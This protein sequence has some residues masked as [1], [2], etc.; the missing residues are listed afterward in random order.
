MKKP[1]AVIVK[2]LG[3]GAALNHDHRFSKQ[4]L[5]LDPNIFD[6]LD[7]E[8]RPLLQTQF[9]RDSSRTIVTENDSPDLGLTYS[10]NFY[11]GCEH[12]CIYCYA[13]PTH[14][15]LNL[16]PGLDFESKI[17]IKEAAPQLLREKLMSPR[18]KPETIMMSGVT[19]CYQPAER[20]FKI[21]KQCLEV[22]NEFKNPVSVITKNSLV[23]RDIDILRDLASSRS[24]SVVLSMT[25]LNPTISK[26]MEP[27]ASVPAARLKAIE[28]L[29]NA[30]IPVFVNIAPVVPGLTDHEIPKILEA[31]ANAGAISAGYTMLR[32][33]Y[34]VKDL[35]VDW[36][37][38]HFPEKK[39]KVLGA[40]RDVRGDKLYDARFGT[41]MTGEGPYA[42]NIKNIFQ[43][44]KR[45]Y[46]LDQKIRTSTEAFRRPGDQ[47][48]LFNLK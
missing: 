33:P 30:G 40:I 14:E 25:S 41:R 12:G 15:Y 19:D 34:S 35:F 22:F 11:R 20:Q 13:R 32:L 5:E 17:F 26:V 24:I 45:K 38:N 4:S 3:R 42:E 28:E 36:L 21:A 43:V 1:P 31:A 37:E 9:F 10:L 44:F 6:D 16:S 39:E 8:E 46:R 47:L 27:R 7:E 48:D 23:T 29:S 18:W 2:T